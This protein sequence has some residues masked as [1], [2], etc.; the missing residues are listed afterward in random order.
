MLA[1]S[2]QHVLISRQSLRMDGEGLDP[3][4]KAGKKFYFSLAGDNE[5]KF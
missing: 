3:V 4:L 2:F 1:R 5:M